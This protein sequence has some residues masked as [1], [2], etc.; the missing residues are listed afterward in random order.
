MC[1]A[2]EE[3]RAEGR[4]EGANQLAELM[5]DLFTQGRTND[6][7]RVASDADYRNKLLQEFQLT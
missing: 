5:A 7:E 4:A 2:F 3:V 6:A 1:K